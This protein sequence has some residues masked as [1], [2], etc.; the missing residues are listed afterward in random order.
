[1]SAIVEKFL[2][3]RIQSQNRY[4]Y[5]HWR[6]YSRYAKNWKDAVLLLLGRGKKPETFR[7]VTITS[8]RKRELDYGNLVGGAKPVPDALVNAGWL[9]DDSPAWAEIA[10]YQRKPQPGEGEGTWVVIYL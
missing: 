3:L 6:E 10:Y 9:R 5:R 7:R 1:M 2:P 8:V 4:Q